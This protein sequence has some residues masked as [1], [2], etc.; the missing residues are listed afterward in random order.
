MS[1][2]TRTIDLERRIRARPE[3]VFAFFTDPEKYRLWQG[4]GASLEPHPGGRY[5][6]DYTRQLHVRCCGRYLV[7]EPPH[8]IVFTWGWDPEPGLPLGIGEVSPDSTTVEITLVPDGEET[9]L[10]LRH[11]GLPTEEAETMHGAQWPIYLDRLATAVA[12]GDPG[13]DQVYMMLEGGNV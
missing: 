11:S 13:P 1:P 12:G 6:V 3:T 8:R 10:R 9:I 5:Q 2:A 4:I 7:V